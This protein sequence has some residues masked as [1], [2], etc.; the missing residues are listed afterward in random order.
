[1]AKKTIIGKLWESIINT[2]VLWPRALLATTTCAG[3]L[4]RNF[5]A[6]DVNGWKSLKY[7]QSLKNWGKKL[8]YALS[9]PVTAR[10]PKLKQKRNK[11]DT[12]PG[13]KER[14]KDMIR[15][16]YMWR[17]TGRVAKYAPQLAIDA[18]LLWS[19]WLESML[20]LDKES[21]MYTGPLP[22]ITQKIKNF[23]KSLIMPFEPIFRWSQNKLWLFGGKKKVEEKKPQVKAEEK[24][25]EEKKPEVK[26]E[27]KKVEEKKP[28]IKTEIKPEPKAEVKK[29]D[30]K[31][32]EEK[33]LESKPDKPVSTPN[34]EK[35]KS[36]DEVKEKSKE[37]AKE[38]DK[39]E[40]TNREWKNLEPKFKVEYGKEFKKM[41]K[42]KPTKEWVIER[43]KTN[44]IW[45]NPE[46][47]ITKLKEENNIEFA[48][49]IEN[50]I[51]NKAA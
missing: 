19:E 10:S 51:L 6:T 50:E 46:E 47:I 26:A 20:Y 9:A 31:P 15:Y 32:I 2:A 16:D 42:G 28:E 23:W 45:E 27:E 48:S 8:T 1:M 18:W 29:H 41:L 4:L 25:V 22:T 30:T 24:K 14:N 35:P 38:K 44:K 39:T 36:I 7:K 12:V 11:L 5:L 34:T 33:K 17:T 49:Y 3:Q 40:K 43:G 13:P 37:E 21:P